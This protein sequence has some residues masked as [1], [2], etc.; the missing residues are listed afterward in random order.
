MPTISRFLGMTITMYYA[1]HH[2]VAHFH[3]RYGEHRASIA[4]ASGGLL[5]GRLPPRVLAL[6]VEWASAHQA[7]LLENW[8]RAQD[9][10]PLNAIEPLA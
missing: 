8:K 2:P 7:E 3:V 10:E 4:I 5:A 6:A 9:D 1:E